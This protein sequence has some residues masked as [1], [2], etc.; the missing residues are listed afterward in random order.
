ML[1]NISIYSAISI[2]FL[3]A[4][5]SGNKNKTVDEADTAFQEFEDFF[6]EEFWK[7]HPSWATSSGFHKYDSVLLVPTEAER[8]AYQKSLTSLLDSLYSYSI[9]ALSPAFQTD[10]ALIENELQSLN[11]YSKEF[12]SYEWNP[13]S[14][15]IARS[16]AR[17]FE[18]DYAPLKDRLKSIFIRLENVPAYYDAAKINLTQATAIHTELGIQQNRGGLYIFE[19]IRESIQNEDLGNMDK[20][21][22]EKRI[23]NAEKA[24][25]DYVSWLENELLVKAKSEGGRSFRIG[26]KQFDEKFKYDINSGYTSEEI[27]N[28]AIIEKEKI[29]KKMFGI[30][31]AIWNKHMP[32]QTPPGDSLIMV[33]ELINKIAEVHVEKDSFITSIKKQLP[34]LV[35]FIKEKQLIYLDPAKPLEVRETP[36]Y[37]RGVAGASISA[38]GPYEKDANTYYNVSPLDE[39]TDQQAESYLREYNHY[40]LQI[41]NIHEAIPGHYTQ[42]V[43]ANQAPS[44][45]KS[46]FGNGTMIEGWACYTERMMLEEGYGNNEPEMWLMYYKW[47]LRIVCNAIIDH[48]IHVLGME[49]AE[50]M[51]L[52]LNEAFQEEAEAVQKWKRARLTQVQLSSYF[53]GLTAIYEFREG[54]KARLRDQFDLKAF[55]ESFLSYGSAPVPVIRE[56]MERKRSS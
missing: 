7:L 9:D 51:N 22:F 6:L 39:M 56:L 4:C 34:E 38:P 49:E 11:W 48:S 23:S 55:H 12:K 32:G 15:N 20:N 17:I 37:M 50:C 40:I 28:K 5:L 10:F 25:E 18:E 27:Y 30:A 47:N 52:L 8:S 24:I 21:E 35:R 43:Y 19:N 16:F 41:L 13:S 26:K 31:S 44:L 1:K 46:I 2:L 3:S 29:H 14:Y 36:L 54:E 53:T 45:I 33:K 42:L